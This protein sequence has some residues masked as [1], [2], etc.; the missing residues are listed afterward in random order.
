MCLTC[1]LACTE[2][3]KKQKMI[4]TDK[5]EIMRTSVSAWRKSVVRNVHAFC[6]C[7]S[8]C[9][10]D[11]SL[12]QILRYDLHNSPLVILSFIREE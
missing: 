3:F 1:S 4:R 9:S 8:G 6:H 5:N 10:T 7:R 11:K 12:D 2:D